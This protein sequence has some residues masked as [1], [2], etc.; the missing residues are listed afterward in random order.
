M[1]REARKR[2][3]E[4]FGPGSRSPRETKRE[5][6]LRLARIP[7][8]PFHLTPVKVLRS[9]SGSLLP[10]AQHGL[11]LI[12]KNCPLSCVSQ[13][14]TRARLR[15]DRRRLPPAISAS[16]GPSV[17]WTQR[18]YGESKTNH[19]QRCD[20]HLHVL[21][22]LCYLLVADGGS[23]DCWSEGHEFG[24]TK[25]PLWGPLSKDLSYVKMSHM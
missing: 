12:L 21:I 17:T 15:M 20:W 16:S 11:Y 3:S 13:Q 14:G 2:I 5:L 6:E 25:M 9:L 22:L 23:V 18:T 8:V 10:N 4:G 7:S 19:K 24:T 1:S